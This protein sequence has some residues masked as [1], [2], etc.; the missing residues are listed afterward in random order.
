MAS[1]VVLISCGFATSPAMMSSYWFV[2]MF[3]RPSRRAI[4]F[5]FAAAASRG[6]VGVEDAEREG[7]RE[8]GDAGRHDP[9]EE[10]H[11]HRLLR[12]L[13]YAARATHA[14]ASGASLNETRARG[15]REARCGERCVRRR[16]SVAACRARKWQK[17]E[18][19][20]LGQMRS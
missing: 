16:R 1:N 7:E 17:L 14:G 9:G 13:L 4:S 19:A 15:A 2:R 11:E 5:F 8:C 18:T 12:P 3:G 20:S 6:A 10:L